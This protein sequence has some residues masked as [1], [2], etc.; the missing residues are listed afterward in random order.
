MTQTLVP[1][2]H[3]SSF[4]GTEMAIVSVLS[5]AHWIAAAVWHEQRDF[6]WLGTASF[7]LVGVAVAAYVIWVRRQE[8]CDSYVHG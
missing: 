1:S 7:A 5:L 3:R 4:G 2:S 6:R 8:R